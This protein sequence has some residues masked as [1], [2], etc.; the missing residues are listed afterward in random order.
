MN[1]DVREGFKWGIF[2]SII[3]FLVIV[4]FFAWT[5]FAQALFFS[6]DTAQVKHNI[7]MGTIQASGNYQI[8]QNSKAYQDAQ[9]SQM[10]Q[11]LSNIEGPQG[12]AITRASLASDDPQQ[13]ALK[14]SEL[15]QVNDFCS[16]AQKVVPENTQFTAQNGSSPS[17][18]QIAGAN[19][20][21]GSAVADPPL[22]RN[23][24]PDGGV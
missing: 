13:A 21:A 12:L 9:I 11:N 17:L 5:Y 22:A 24:V 16:E 10:N 14:A 4:A 19:C 15:N 23:P 6:V 18:A 3:G 7:R 8:T 2:W 20:L 1:G